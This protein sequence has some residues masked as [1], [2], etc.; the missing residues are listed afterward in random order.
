MPWKDIR[1]QR[2][3]IRRHYYA[4]RDV[5]LEKAKR[6][7]EEIKQYV[8][9][10]KESSPCSDCGKKY[11]YFVMDFD[12]IDEKS[13]EIHVLRSL[14]SKKRLDEELAKCEL[15][16]AN[17]HRVRTYNRLKSRALSSVD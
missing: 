12:H 6:R 8:N 16:C 3:A 9:N 15:V 5:Y 10:L 2:E 13:I 14:S 7:R 11:P 1:K 4:N 17:C